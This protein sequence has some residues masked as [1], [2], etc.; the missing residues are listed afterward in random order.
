MT[1]SKT[2]NRYKLEKD[3]VIGGWK[4]VER[5]GVGGNGE[6]WEVS[7][8]DYENHAMKLLKTTDTNIYERFKAETHILSTIKHDGVIPLIDL[9]LPDDIK[10]D[11]PWFIMPKAIGFEKYAADKTP[12]E[13]ARQFVLLGDTLRYL[14]SKGISHRDIKPANIL[15][16]N[17]RLCFAD[18]GLVKYP[19]KEN[20]TPE[21][22]DVGAKFTMAPEMRREASLADGLPAD[23]FSLAKSL[24]IVLTKQEK[25]FDGQYNPSSI[26]SIKNYCQGL[27]TTPL[28]NLLIES[29][30]TDAFKRPNAKQFT[31]R[32]VEWIDLNKDFHRRNLSEWLEV[33]QTIFPTGSPSQATWIDID[34]ICSVLNEIGNR[35]SLNHMFY[36]TGGGMDLLGAS[37]AEENGMLALH[38]GGSRVEILKPKK[39]TYESVGFHPQWNYFRLEAAEIEP[40]GIE[41]EMSNDGTSEYLLEIEPGRYVEYYHWH[42]GEYDGEPLPKE[43]R[44]IGRFLK[45]SF[46]LFSKR[47][48]YN[49][50]SDTYDARHNK[51]SETSFRKHI[52][53]A[54]RIAFEHEAEEY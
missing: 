10:T 11:T 15:F 46:V 17:D 31:S 14:H 38:V 35:Q 44:G 45:G 18:F 51:M 48:I 1:K 6:V 22:R 8:N 20:I 41:T 4:L 7:R 42:N 27:Y 34:S 21:K 23:V 52:E 9:H 33:Q 32:L 12:I 30:D 54:A 26:L 2:K 47:S 49:R 19:G 16:Y 53:M 39:L 36:P 28:D 25:G 50:T 29:T 3:I 24:W 5:L 40:T 13:L 37:K 43:A